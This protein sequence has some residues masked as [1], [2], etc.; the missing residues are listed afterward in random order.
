MATMTM[1]FGGA[2]FTRG[3]PHGRVAQAPLRLTLRGRR[4]L[5]ALLLLVATL[6]AF[7]ALSALRGGSVSALSQVSAPTQAT[8]A[9]VVKPGDTLWTI[10]VREMPGVDPIV[11][12]DRIRTLNAMT[13]TST[14]L[15][16]STI[17]IPSV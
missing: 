12:V 16:G 17:A 7:V 13:P 8:Q 9:V 5:F 4:V 15:A 3:N 11:G 2:G 14:L 6:L 1:D 10:A